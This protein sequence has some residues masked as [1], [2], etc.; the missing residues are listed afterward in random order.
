MM[1]C[2][3]F[4]IVTCLFYGVTIEMSVALITRAVLGNVS[5]M[6]VVSV[7]ECAHARARWQITM[8]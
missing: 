8:S 3:V 6:L 7:A 2:N 4:L 5:I 1:Y